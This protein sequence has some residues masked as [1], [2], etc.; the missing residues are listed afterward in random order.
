MHNI[1]MV[2]PMWLSF[3]ILRIIMTIKKP[4]INLLGPLFSLEDSPN[5]VA[6]VPLNRDV[7]N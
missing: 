7:K 4:G 1:L 3:Q 6:S 2:L 5:S